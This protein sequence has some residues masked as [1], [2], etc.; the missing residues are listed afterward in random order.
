[1]L[2]RSD[3]ETGQ[4]QSIQV[5]ASSGLTKEEVAKMM[6]NAKDHLVEARGN[7][8]FEGVK[9]EAEKLV[10]DIE[11]MFPQVES[12]VAS[13][14]FGRE[15]ISKARGILQKTRDAMNARD[16]AGVK[17]Q[18]EALSRTHRMFKGVVSRPN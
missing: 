12:V 13:S 2:F 17:D 6:E 9:Q 11:K 5:T 18:M 14:D 15:A 8:E 16:A 7:D 1:M 3:L 10:L 4:A